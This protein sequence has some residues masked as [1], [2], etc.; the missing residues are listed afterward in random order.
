MHKN[1]WLVLA[2]FAATI[3][4]CNQEQMQEMVENTMVTENQTPD[5]T[6]RVKPGSV[7]DGDTFRAVA[8]VTNEEIKVRLA[9][10]DAPEIKQAGGIEARDYLRSMLTDNREI[11]LMGAEKDQYGRSVVEVFAMTD[12]PGIEVGV[13]GEMILAGMAHYYERYNKSCPEN[14]E[15]YEFLEQQ[16][17]S[18]KGGVWANGNAERP[19][20][21][22]Q[23]NK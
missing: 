14:A 20:D 11:I 4:A 6:W 10:I 7:H 13:N 2:L 17:I 3:T 12:T 19:W 1:L 21:W 23:Q 5:K 15:Q 22:R 18:N 16:A 9:C 8:D